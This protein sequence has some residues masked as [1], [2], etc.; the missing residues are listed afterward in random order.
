MTKTRAF[1]NLENTVIEVILNTLS[2]VV[3]PTPNLIVTLTSVI[4]DLMLHFV[5]NIRLNYVK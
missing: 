1:V 4:Y 5:I 2:V 3:V